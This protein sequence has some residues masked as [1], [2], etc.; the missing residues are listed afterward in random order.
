MKAM[1]ASLQRSISSKCRFFGF[2]TVLRREKIGNL[3][4]KPMQ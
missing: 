3:G 2:I 4:L 1:D